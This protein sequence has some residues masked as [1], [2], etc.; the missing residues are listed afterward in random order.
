MR[1]PP[2]DRFANAFGC[3]PKESL[4]RD[5]QRR[6]IDAEKTLQQ[7]PGVARSRLDAL[8][9]ESPRH[10]RQRRTGRLIVFVSSL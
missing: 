6:S 1:E 9:S 7:N 3:I 2:P 4:R 8:G 5:Q 10:L